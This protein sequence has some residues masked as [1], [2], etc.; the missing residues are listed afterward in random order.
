MAATWRISAAQTS[1]GI[2]DLSDRVPAHAGDQ[3]IAGGRHMFIEMDGRDQ[4]RSANRIPNRWLLPDFTSTKPWFVSFMY[5]YS[6]FSI[7]VPADGP[8]SVR[9]EPGR[10]PS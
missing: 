4:R 6:N 7:G 1:H 5:R 9:L 3:V 2:G 8:L 10:S